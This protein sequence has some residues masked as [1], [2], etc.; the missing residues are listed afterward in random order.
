[1]GN[2]LTR[3]YTRLAA[4]EVER[5]LGE[6]VRSTFLFAL[7]SWKEGAGRLMDFADTLT[8]YNRTPPPDDADDRALRQDWLAV[9][10]YLRA[11][12]RLGPRGS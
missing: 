2:C 12:L 9:G 1:M 5:L 4:G 3:A 6:K 8:E 10:D 7:P 11:A